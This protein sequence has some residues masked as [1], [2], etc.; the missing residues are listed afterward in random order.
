MHLAVKDP[1]VF[2]PSSDRRNT[3]AGM[4]F[5]LTW[6][7]GHMGSGTSSSPSLGKRLASSEFVL[8]GPRHP[9]SRLLFNLIYSLISLNLYR[10]KVL[11][12]DV[13][14]S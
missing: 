12:S 6:L 14:L 7:M 2:Y 5:V 13:C 3:P 8:D 1:S 4:A 11:V 9:T 10:M